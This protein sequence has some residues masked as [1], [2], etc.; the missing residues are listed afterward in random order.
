MSMCL[1]AE[2]QGPIYS[3]VHPGGDGGGFSDPL[4]I[5]KLQIK[6]KKQRKKGI[7]SYV[8]RSLD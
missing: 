5:L 3:R 2:N 6:L 8:E 1:E 7:L 4:L